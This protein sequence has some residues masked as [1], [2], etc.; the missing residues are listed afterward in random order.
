M[1]PW[2]FI[3]DIIARD[4]NTVTEENAELIFQFVKSYPGPFTKEK[5]VQL[6][7]MSGNKHIGNFLYALDI[8]LQKWL[9]D[10]PLPLAPLPTRHSIKDPVEALRLIQINTFNV[11]LVEPAILTP[12][13][14]RIV[15]AGPEKDRIFL[16]P[17]LNPELYRSMMSEFLQNPS[18]FEHIDLT[19][20]LTDEEII[21]LGYKQEPSTFYQKLREAI[22]SSAR[23]YDDQQIY[24]HALCHGSLLTEM[25]PDVK[26][27]R[28]SSVPLGSC[29]YMR[30]T[31]EVKMHNETKCETFEASTVDTILRLRERELG[32]GDERSKRA[33]AIKIVSEIKKVYLP[34]SPDPAVAIEE[35]ED[36][37]MDKVFTTNGEKVAF[38]EIIT[39]SGTFNLFS[40]SDTWT[41]GMIIDMLKTLLGSNYFSIVM[42]DYSCSGDETRGP[43]E[44]VHAGK[45]TRNRTRR[46]RTRSKRSFFL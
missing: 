8:C 2:R 38:L 13:M 42:G 12:E 37:I 40:L 16:N 39:R 7:T 22:F 19:T 41:L 33:E 18:I 44:L 1:D 30:K 43:T 36:Q 46:K 24:I 9:G 14:V 15:L 35:E 27:T 4:H 29:E 6:D 21:R 34:P 3:D 28:Y 45:R 23:L 31:K 32:D 17:E 11:H 5:Y 10:P 25:S 20:L 26:I